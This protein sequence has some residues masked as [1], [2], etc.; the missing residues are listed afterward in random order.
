[1]KTVL[2]EAAIETVADAQAAVEGGADRLELCSALD[3]GGLTPSVGML[4]E[5]RELTELPIFVMIRPRGGDFVYDAREV[6]VMIRDITSLKKSKP[7]GFVLGVLEPNGQIATEACEKLLA[8]AGRLPVV[9]H[10]AFDRAPK[11]DEALEKCVELGFRRILTSGGEPTGLAGAP[12]IALLQKQAAKRIEIL[13]CGRVNSNNAVDILRATRCNQLHGS[14]ATALPDATSRGRRGYGN[15]SQLN[16]M[17]LA[18]VRSAFQGNW[19][20]QA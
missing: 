4:E 13:P 7:N 11:P 18:K 14:F 15:R 16:P 5:I 19:D 3:L 6:S 20:Q 8:A 17:E 1:M 9:F 2:L 12:K 10:R